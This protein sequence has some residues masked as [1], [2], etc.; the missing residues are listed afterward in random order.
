MGGHNCISPGSKNEFYS[1]KTKDKRGVFFFHKLPLKR[2]SVLLRL[3]IHI[4]TQVPLS[5]DFHRYTNLI[6][7]L[8]Q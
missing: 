3:P 2:R 8:P 5:Q 4:Q 1:V 6:N 7:I